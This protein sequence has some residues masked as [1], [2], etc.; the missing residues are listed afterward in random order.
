MTPLGVGAEHGQR[1]SLADE[2]ALGEHS[3][4]M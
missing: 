3:L 1:L 2:L 4:L